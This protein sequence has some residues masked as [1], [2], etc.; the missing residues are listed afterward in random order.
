MASRFASSRLDASHTMSFITWDPKQVMVYQAVQL[1]QHIT[2]KYTDLR[3]FIK[4]NCDQPWTSVGMTISQTTKYST[5]KNKLHEN[6]ND[7]WKTS[8]PVVRVWKKLCQTQEPPNRSCTLNLQKVKKYKV[9]EVH[10]KKTLLWFHQEGLALIQHPTKQLGKSSWRRSELVASMHRGSCWKLKKKEPEER[11][12]LNNIIWDKDQLVSFGADSLTNNSSQT[13]EDTV[14]KNGNISNTDEE[15][16]ETS[17]T[18][19]NADDGCKWN[20]PLWGF[21]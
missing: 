21:F 15:T 12:E 4:Q 6:P 7:H 3:T 18:W 9:Q 8:T 13:L 17:S 5:G 10:L 20:P 16:L 14:M 2:I 1:G 19:G 11:K